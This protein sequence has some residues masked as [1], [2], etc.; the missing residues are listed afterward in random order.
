[1]KASVK[2]R[3]QIYRLITSE[4]ATHWCTNLLKLVLGSNFFGAVH[5][6]GGFALDFYCSSFFFFQAIK[7]N[8]HAE[9]AKTSIRGTKLL[10]FAVVV[11]NAVS[12]PAV[13]GVI[14]EGCAISAFGAS[15]SKTVPFTGMGLRFVTEI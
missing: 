6:S 12:N 7:N 5:K 3:W 15:S 1:M 8:S 13:E 10:F 2:R 14:S 4:Q 11:L 9:T